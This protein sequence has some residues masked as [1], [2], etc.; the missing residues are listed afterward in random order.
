MRVRV[1]ESFGVRNSGE[2]GA[3]SE[4]YLVFEP[5]LFE[6]SLAFGNVLQV[7]PHAT[8]ALRDLGDLR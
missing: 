6:N 2:E 3:K 5:G 7:D 4:T 8:S 1:N